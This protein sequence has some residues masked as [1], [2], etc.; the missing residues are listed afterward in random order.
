V[1]QTTCDTLQAKLMLCEA[2][3]S[4]EALAD[5]DVSDRWAALPVLPPLWEQALAQ[6]KARMGTG[7]GADSMV[8]E[9]LLQ[10]E[11]ALDLPSPPE[12]Q[13]S[14]RDLKLRALKAALEGGVRPA[15]AALGVDH[16]TAEVIGLSGLKAVQRQRLHCLIVGLRTVNPLVASSPSVP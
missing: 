6:R 10:L 12:H 11:A 3:E 15:A 16:M 14:R 9:A 5:A 1:W 2:Q 8:D 7:D 13:A 4:A